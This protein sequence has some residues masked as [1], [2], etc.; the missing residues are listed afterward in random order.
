MKNSA[1]QGR[2]YPSRLTAEVENT[3]RDLQNSSY[4][5]KA[6]FKN[7]F[8]IHSKHLPILKGVSPFCSLF[9]FFFLHTKNNTTSS[10]GFLGLW[11]NNLQRAAPLTSFWHHRLNKM[12]WAALLRLWQSSFQI[13][14]TQLVMVNC[15]LL[16]NQKWGNIFFEWIIIIIHRS[17]GE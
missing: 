11:F 9:F 12:Q 17:G 8:I 4:P 10:P 3:L 7:W 13:W 15:V 2:C 16:T 1:D 6:K 14:S 5:M